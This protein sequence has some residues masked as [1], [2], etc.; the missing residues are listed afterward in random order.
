MSREHELFEELRDARRQLFRARVGEED[1]AN[2]L[3]R[4]EE[5]TN[6]G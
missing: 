4:A 6:E 2:G 5:H 3:V 1:V